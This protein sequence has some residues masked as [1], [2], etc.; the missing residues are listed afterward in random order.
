M[1][2]TTSTELEEE[3]LIE[4]LGL[5]SLTHA[6]LVK[7]AAEVIYQQRVADEMSSGQPAIT[8]QN[9]SIL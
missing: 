6:Q 3:K 5:R 2:L 7:L 1:R 4:E 8:R 9:D